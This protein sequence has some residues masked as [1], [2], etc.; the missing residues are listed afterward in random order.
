MRIAILGFL[1][2]AGCES[3]STPPSCQQA[4]GHYYSLGCTF[5]DATG[6]TVP[7]EWI[8][9]DCQSTAV[10]A[11]AQCRDEL[12]AWL[13]C[14]NDLKQCAASHCSQEHMTLLD[15]IKVTQSLL[16]VQ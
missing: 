11:S 14:F 1:I 5:L 9:A 8:T 3:N 10:A 2:M 16:L 6:Q 4:F 15:C 12:D 7:Q 13:T